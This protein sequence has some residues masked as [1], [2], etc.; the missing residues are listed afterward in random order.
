L[1]VVPIVDDDSEDDE[2]PRV[3]NESDDNDSL[4]TRSDGISVVDRPAETVLLD[5]GR[6]ERC[7]EAAANDPGV[8]QMALRRGVWF[9]IVFCVLCGRV[10]DEEGN[11]ERRCWVEKVRGRKEGRKDRNRYV[12]GQVK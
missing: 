11:E 5:V 6:L 7:D 4:D 10:I 2:R 9:E 1:D 3:C 8:L 12:D